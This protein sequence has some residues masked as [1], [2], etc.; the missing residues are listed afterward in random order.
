MAKNFYYCIYYLLLYITYKYGQRKTNM[1]RRKTTIYKMRNV[2][3]DKESVRGINR[4]LGTVEENVSEFVDT[5][6]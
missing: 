2:L 3:C 6:I 1:M 4:N 5:E